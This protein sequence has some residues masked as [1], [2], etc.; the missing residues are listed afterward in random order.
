MKTDRAKE[1]RHG[2]R[3]PS[4]VGEFAQNLRYVSLTSFEILGRSTF[5]GKG[6]SS[7]NSIRL[8]RTCDLQCLPN[9]THQGDRFVFR[10]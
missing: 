7:T 10:Q 9:V 4:I 3:D 2:W 6:L 5:S 1:G 8:S